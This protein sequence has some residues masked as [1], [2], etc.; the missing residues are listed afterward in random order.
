MAKICE[1]DKSFNKWL[2]SRP[3]VIKEMA[4][5]WPPDR[6][7][8]MKSTGQRVFI[9]SYNEQR[10][11]CV[12]ITGEYNLIDFPREVFGIPIEDLT[13]CDLPGEGE[14]LGVTQTEEETADMLAMLRAVNKLKGKMQ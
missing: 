11:V 12:G 5:S 7:Y 6:L 2:K 13:E 9:V 14:E 3:K 10:T 4:T 1:L 8:R